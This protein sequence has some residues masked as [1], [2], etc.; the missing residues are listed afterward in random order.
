MEESISADEEN[1]TFSKKLKKYLKNLTDFS[2]YSAK[3]ILYI[4]IFVVLII[5]SLI[6]LYI[7]FFVDETF[8]YR[9]VIEFFVNPVY[10][11]GIFGIFLFVLIMAIQGL[12]VPLPSEI[13][14]LGT[15][16]IW[17]WFYGGIMGII[18]S[19]VAGLLCYYISQR[20]GRPLAEKFVGEKAIEIADKFIKK[21]GTKAIII[22]RF[23][24]V[25]PFDVISYTA[26]LV[27]IDV[28]KYSIGTLIGSIFRAF[29]YSTLGS[30]LFMNYGLSLPLDFDTLPLNVILIQS[31][32][33]NSILVI[34]LASL[35][36]MFVLYYLLIKK[37]DKKNN[38]N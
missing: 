8:L 37:L 25:I 27:D 19:M 38:E 4:I 36:I 15:G 16:M 5:A 10:N 9:F 6:L 28:K 14:L 3:T 7:I 13:V 34:I 21:H 17:G 29:F 24:P 33:F 11:L 35:A 30:L 12:I 32:Y 22:T 23:I 31:N 1:Q 2:Q 26:G 20:G 18:G